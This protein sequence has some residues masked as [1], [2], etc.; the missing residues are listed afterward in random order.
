MNHSPTSSSLFTFFT[1]GG[2]MAWCRQLEGDFYNL[3]AKV[4]GVLPRFTRQDD[5]FHLQSW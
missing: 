2:K 4:M 5:S 3:G 1:N